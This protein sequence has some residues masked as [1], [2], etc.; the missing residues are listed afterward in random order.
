MDDL[1]RRPRFGQNCF[2][3]TR[4]KILAHHQGRKQH[5]TKI[6][7]PYQWLIE[8]YVKAQQVAADHETLDSQRG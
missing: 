5:R 6:F 4:L 2:Q 3:P 7:T 8:S 1:V